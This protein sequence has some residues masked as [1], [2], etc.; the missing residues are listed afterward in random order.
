METMLRFVPL[1]LLLLPDAALACPV[2]DSSTGEAVRAGIAESFGPRLLATL[3]PF[4][5]LIVVVAL[6]NACWPDGR[7][8]R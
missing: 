4:P 8:T 3:A 5:V 1:V 2:C 6:V 7:S